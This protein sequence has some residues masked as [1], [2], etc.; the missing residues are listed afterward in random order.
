MTA[1]QYRYVKAG[2]RTE[3]SQNA[4]TA[5]GYGIYST[6]KHEERAPPKF[7]RGRHFVAFTSIHARIMNQIQSLLLSVLLVLDSDIVKFRITFLSYFRG[8]FGRARALL[9]YRPFLEMRNSLDMH[10]CFP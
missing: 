2:V 9:F 4:G 7:P 6:V 8:C 10:I 5:T 1:L 3:N